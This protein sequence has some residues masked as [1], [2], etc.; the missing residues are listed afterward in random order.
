MKNE[1]ICHENSIDQYIPIKKTTFPEAAKIAI[2]EEKEVKGT[3]G[4]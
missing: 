1:V 3:I 4:S 2:D